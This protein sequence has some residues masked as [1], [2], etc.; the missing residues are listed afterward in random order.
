MFQYIVLYAALFLSL[1]LLF[2]S[3][4]FLLFHLVATISGA[5]YAGSNQQRIV[6][7]LKLADIQK[8]QKIVDLG[9]GDGR[10]LIKV[11]KKHQVECV[12]YEINPLWYFVSRFK[13]K[14]N[15]V[16]DKVKVY[17]KSYWP[18]KLSNFDVIFLYLIPY[19]MNKMAKKLQ[20][21]LKPG[22]IVVS[23][24]F[25]FNDWQPVKEENGVFLYKKS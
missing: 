8:G 23:N 9:S 13:I 19:N 7:M 16:S 5:P 3:V 17:R 1:A 10:I 25:R 21:E 18:E 15:R 11:A 2:C 24:G 20:R 6:T 14:K 4:L 12:G 22:A